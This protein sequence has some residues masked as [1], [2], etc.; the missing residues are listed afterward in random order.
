MTKEKLYCADCGVI[1]ETEEYYNTNGDAICENCNEDYYP[2]E[3]CG[4]ITL[5]D[6][7]I[8]VN[9]GSEYVCEDC[10]DVHYYLCDDCGNYYTYSNCH[11]YESIDRY[12]CTDCL[13]NYYTCADCGDVLDNNDCYY[14][15]WGNAYCQS[16]WDYR[17]TTVH[18]WDYKPN[19]TFYGDGNYF[20]GVELEIDGGNDKYD[21]ARE[22]Q[23]L[24]DA[25]YLKNDGSLSC[26]GV[27]IVTH[28]ATLNYH[29]YQMQ[30]DDITQTARDYGYKSHDTDTCGLHIHVSRTAFGAGRLEQ[31]LNIAKTM[32]IFDKFWEDYIVPFSRRDYDKINSWARKPDAE[33]LPDDDETTATDKALNT[34]RHGRYQAINLENRTTV[35]FRIFRGT[36][37]YNTIIA[38]IQW[39]DTLINYVNQTPLKKLWETSW[40]DM[41]GRT[42]YQELKEYLCKRKL[43]N[44][45]KGESECA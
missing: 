12:I 44:T 32:L 28:P 24:T 3:N 39:L 22:I 27:E 31:E 30:W 25:L 33:I 19:P 10:A 11:Y 17:T 15:D 26:A 36:L 34:R 23:E 21:V 6:N 8:S 40:D 7:I 20:Y 35:E 29:M 37:K 4:N 38:S 1:I 16:C 41:F 5:R 14:D 45:K 18:D 43:L 2:C 9:H 13:D 42:E